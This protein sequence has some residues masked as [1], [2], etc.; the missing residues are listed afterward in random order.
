MNYV[1]LNDQEY[2][3]DKIKL[4]GFKEVDVDGN[5]RVDAVFCHITRE[6]LE[7]IY[8]N[9]DTGDRLLPQSW[10]LRDAGIFVLS[11]IDRDILYD[12]NSELIEKMLGLYSKE[13]FYIEL[14]S[15][16]RPESYNQLEQYIFAYQKS[17]GFIAD[18]LPEKIENPNIFQCLLQNIEKKLL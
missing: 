6:I 17:F 13:N 4:H 10:L 18:I 7:D 16:N 1:I 3:K 11:K 2:F 14:R 5:E 15:Y 8:N 9:E 12:E